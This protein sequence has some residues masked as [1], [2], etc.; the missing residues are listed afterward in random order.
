MAGVIFLIFGLVAQLV[1]AAAKL[2]MQ[3]VFPASVNLYSY[4][5]H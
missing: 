2:R 5:K 1:F 4:E 3:S